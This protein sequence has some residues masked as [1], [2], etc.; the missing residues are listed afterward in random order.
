VH[1]NRAISST[2]EMYLKTLHEA[3][4]DRGVARVS[5]LAKRLD[6]SAG[7]VSSV[8][9][10][11]EH[12]HLVQHERYGL[13]A[14]T[15]DGSGIAECVLHR[16]DTIHALLTEVLGVDATTAA[17]D[18]CMMEHAVS[19]STIARMQELV[20]QQR[21]HRVRVRLPR[22]GAGEDLCA[23]CESLGVCRASG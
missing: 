22:A 3:R 2:H 4:G 19:S 12:M 20:K 1:R 17:V 21:E 15:P 10:K 14:L 5:D 7:T 16:Y 18:A 23:G 6:V 11:L 13:V 8:L 9:K